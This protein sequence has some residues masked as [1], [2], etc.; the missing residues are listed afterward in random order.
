[1]GTAYRWGKGELL[2]YITSG[3]LGR[4]ELSFHS[5]A[6]LGSSDTETVNGGTL[7]IVLPTPLL[8]RWM[9]LEIAV[10]IAIMKSF[11]LSLHCQFL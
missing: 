6:S 9:Q 5:C 4:K 3:R 8:T 11:Y 7:L 1:M 2:C 10:C